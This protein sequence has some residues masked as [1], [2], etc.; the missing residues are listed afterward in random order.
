MKKGTILVGAIFLGALFSFGAQSGQDHKALFEK[1]RYTMES[2]G[3]INGAIKLFGE[4][5]QKYPK[6]RDYAAKAQLYIGICLEKQGVDEARKA[7]Q[8]VIDN[9]PEQ[10]EPVKTAR[11][12][13]AALGGGAGAPA[14]VSS[15]MRIRKVWA[16]DFDPVAAVSPDGRYVAYVKDGAGD[17]YIRDLAT[18]D[19]RRMTTETTFKEPVQF[20]GDPAWSKDGKKIVYVW[21]NKEKTELRMVDVAARSMKI[22]YDDPIRTS[23]IPFDWFSDGRFVLAGSGDK[24]NA[25]LSLISIEDGS[26][27]DIL[28]ENRFSAG[29]GG[30]RLSP[31]GRYIVFSRLGKSGPMDRDIDVYDIGAGKVTSSIVHPAEDKSPFWSSDGKTIIFQSNRTGSNDLYGQSVSEGLVQGEPFLLKSDQ[32]DMF[33]VGISKNDQFFYSTYINNR[34]VVSAKIDRKSGDVVRRMEKITR[35]FEGHNESPVLSVDG[36]AVAFYSTRNRGTRFSQA[37]TIVVRRLDKGEEKAYPVGGQPLRV[38]SPLVWSRDLK[39]LLFISSDANTRNY[40]VLRLDLASGDIKAAAPASQNYLSVCTADGNVGIGWEPVR[41]DT[42]RSTK[43]YRKNLVSGERKDLWTGSGSMSF[44]SLSPDDQFVCFL[45]SEKSTQSLMLLSESGGQPKVLWTENFPEEEGGGPFYQTS[46][47]TDS[48]NVLVTKRDTDK[49]HHLWIVPID[50]R[51]P[52]KTGIAGD[53]IRSYRIHP[54]TGLVVYSS[55]E[56]STVDLW[57]IENF[58][59]KTGKK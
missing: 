26:V 59:P 49:K 27:K 34:D 15:E 20:A 25:Y 21:Y 52:L 14:A 47:T 28:S 12:K 44:L 41:S 22:L 7:F 31:D 58:L 30:A 51:K 2:L 42:G 5:V 33:P 54:E 32:G 6:E 56:F 38:F 3:D 39:S 55:G 11:M 29:F 4:L 40:S 8:S 48:R 43:I 13:L 18:K 36:R 37:D 23:V 50:G 57:V 10:S 16:D 17:L 53:M 9:Y 24:Q 19:D 45:N 35:S 1:A 46:W